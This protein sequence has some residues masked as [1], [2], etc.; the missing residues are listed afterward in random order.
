MRIYL[1]QHFN[2]FLTFEIGTFSGPLLVNEPL[3]ATVEPLQEGQPH[4]PVPYIFETRGRSLPDRLATGSQR[5]QIY[6]ELEDEG[7]DGS[8]M[9]KHQDFIGI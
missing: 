7:E 2:V 6:A 5:F 1:M 8:G 9:P 4:L 3:K